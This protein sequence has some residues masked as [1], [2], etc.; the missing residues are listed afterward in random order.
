MDA[1]SA[2]EKARAERALRGLDEAG[3]AE[4]GSAVSLG[5]FADQ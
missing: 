5:E 2:K 1:V 3:G 4:R